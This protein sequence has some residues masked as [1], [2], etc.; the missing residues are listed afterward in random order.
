MQNVLDL[1]RDWDALDGAMRLMNWDR[2]VL[3]PP[4][5]ALARGLHLERLARMSHALLTSDRLKREVE[6]AK[7]RVGEDSDELALLQ[8]LERDIEVESK[9]PEEL[10]RRHA[11]VSSDSYQVWKKARAESDFAAM[12]PYYAE[13]FAI[14]KESASCL[15]YTDH[16]YDPLIDMYEEG[17]T[18][19]AA[20]RMFAEIGPA[21]KS[22][23]SEIMES[24]KTIDDSALIRDWDQEKLRG[25]AQETAQQIGYRFDAG[26]LDIAPNAFATGF[27]TNDVRMTTRPSEHIKGIVSSSL[28]EMGHGLYEQG[29]NPAW[30]QTPLG[31]GISLAV[32]ESQSRFWENIVGR[33]RPFWSFFLPRLQGAFPELGGLSLDQFYAAMNK[34]KP[35]PIRV[36]AD[37]L[38]YNLHIQIRFEIEVAMVEGS[39][40]AGQI[41]E[42]WNEKYREYLGFVPASDSVGCL[43]DVH[44]SKGSIGYFSTYSMGNLIG[45]QIWQTLRTEVEDT[46]GLISEGRFEPILGWLQTNLYRLGKR[47]QPR[48]LVTRITGSEMSAGAWLGYATEK[49]RALYGL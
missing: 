36:G 22:L 21:I 33:S 6:D 23:V 47:Y 3:M 5:G 41:P 27:S 40:E 48:E 20:R 34:V 38:T 45:A 42:V 4:G 37:E 2:Q 28:H 49:Y 16:P 19:A 12:K 30:N 8:R 29:G 39:M 44:W 15:G 10:V 24:G 1:Y 26:R 17:A 32:H 7:S 31:G 46:D 43:Q 13:L 14:A 9:I 11:R 25:F 35:E 18:T